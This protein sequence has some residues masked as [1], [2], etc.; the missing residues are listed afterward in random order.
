[1]GH[2]VGDLVLKTVTEILKQQAREVDLV[3]R[4]GGEEFMLVLPE[5]LKKDAVL[6]A[7]RI[8]LAV[9]KHALTDA[10]K[11]PLPGITVSLGVSS[12]PE[13]GSEKDQLIDYADK[14]LYK[15]K[16]GGRDL[17]RH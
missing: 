16:A 4:Y 13:N 5:T 11:N 1:F 8:R 3:A 9:K 12:Y 7:E 6:L 10:Q 17:V 14:C 2:P 15:A